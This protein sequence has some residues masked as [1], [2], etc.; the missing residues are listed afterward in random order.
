MWTIPPDGGPTGKETTT[1]YQL[2]GEKEYCFE[3][4]LAATKVEEVLEGGS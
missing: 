2:I 1:T 3:R 4:K